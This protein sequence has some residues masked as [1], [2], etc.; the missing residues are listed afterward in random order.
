MFLVL[1]HACNT[2][3]RFLVNS[4]KSLDSSKME[5]MPSIKNAKAGNKRLKEIDA[6]WGIELPKHMTR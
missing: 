1:Q 2:R 6:G 4:C 5:A 3:K